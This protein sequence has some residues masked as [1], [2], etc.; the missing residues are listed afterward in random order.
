MGKS[1]TNWKSFIE[2]ILISK[3]NYKVVA[4]EVK[5]EIQEITYQSSDKEP[6]TSLIVSYFYRTGSLIAFRFYNPSVRGY[7]EFSKNAYF[8]SLQ[9]TKPTSYGSPG[10]DFTEPNKKGLLSVF[11]KGVTGKEIQY[12]KDS[13]IIKSKVSVL[14][15]RDTHTYKYR[16]TKSPVIDI[17]LNKNTNNDDHLEEKTI[18]LKTIFSGL[19]VE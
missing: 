13:I 7:N 1:T 6:K 18:D 14:D 12:M 5:R 2:E 16:F 11:K 19:I 8:Y 9:F 3:N 10:L 4:N 15:G 17:L